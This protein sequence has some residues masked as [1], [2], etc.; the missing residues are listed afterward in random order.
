VKHIPQLVAALAVATALPAYPQLSVVNA[1]S[2]DPAQPVAGGSFASAFGQ[3][4]CAQTATG[5][6]DSSGRYPTQLGGCSVSISGTPAMMQYT[7][8]GLVNFVMP[9]GIPAGQAVVS[10]NNGSAIVTGGMT[11]ATAGPGVFALNGMGMGEGAI[12]NTATWGTGAFSMMTDGQPTVAA[13]YATGL[14]LTSM[15]S[16]MI[17]GAPAAVLWAGAIPGYP[18]LE[19]INVMMP[20]GAAGAGR[21]PVMATSGGRNSNVT[22][23]HV[24][25]T[26]AMMQGMPGWTS[27]MSLASNMPRGHEMAAMAVNPA[28][29]S[30][31]IADEND[32]VVRVISLATGQTTATIPIP[33]GAHANAIAVNGAGSLAAAT[34]SSLASV[35]LID[36]S[37]NKMIA[38]IGTGYYP[39]G[40]TFSGTNL[41]VA[42]GGSANVSV[43]DTLSL[44]VTRT[45]SA[46]FGASAIAAQGSTAVVANMQAGSV[47]LLDLSGWTSTTIALPAGT[48]PHAV[49]ISPVLN[50]AVISAPMSGGYFLLDLATRT[51]TRN[52]SGTIGGMGA[53][54]LVVNGSAAYFANQMNA[55]V[56]ALDLAAGTA[57][58]TYA[59]DPGP[60]ALALNS[61]GNQLLVLAEGTGTLDV[62]DLRSGAIVARYDAG[63]TESPGRFSVPVVS[64]ITPAGGTAGSTVSLTLTG[65]NFQG[66][67]TILFLAATGDPGGMMG[68]M[69]GAMVTQ[70]PAI[71]VSNLRVS[72]DG[73]RI[74]ATVSI[75]ANASA[76]PRAV[77]LQTSYGDVMMMPGS[78][79]V[80]TV[81]R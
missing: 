73:T 15:P 20:G 29:N 68:Q 2:F 76:G 33:N 43:I 71:S 42:N 62:L 35:A 11:S 60:V 61:S 17:G 1:A 45:L 74:D 38:A 50:K 39:S 27:G 80:F 78:S 37:Q 24:L 79:V 6:P 59:T 55:G 44:A 5:T 47:S 19:Q 48:R 66:L 9:A 69:G 46:G 3:N 58:A 22:F 13:I 72:P 21:V 81:T 36:L 56:T 30:V 4:L 49:A 25:P 63:Q 41:L 67:Q 31:L 7:S 34:L 40:L 51:I 32:D 77:R 23:M 53:G 18:G 57:A 75:A 14:D 70:D 65:S 28:S 16:V 8:P 64:A 52:P 54:A 12:A 26:T 10:I